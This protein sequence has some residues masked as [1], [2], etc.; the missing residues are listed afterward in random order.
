MR[1]SFPS[2][3][4]EERGFSAALGTEEHRLAQQ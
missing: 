3:S 2:R 4:Q 1:V